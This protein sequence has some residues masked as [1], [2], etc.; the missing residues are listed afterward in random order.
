M[1]EYVRVNVSTATSPPGVEDVAGNVVGEINMQLPANIIGSADQVASARMAVM[2][3]NIPLT[4]IPQIRVELREYNGSYIES[5]FNVSFT[6]HRTLRT[7]AEIGFLVKYQN[8]FSGEYVDYPSADTG[9]TNSQY[10]SSP[11]YHF[12]TTAQEA[13]EASRKGYYDYKNIQEFLND[14]SYTVDLLLKRIMDGVVS[15]PSASNTFAYPTQPFTCSF[16]MNADSTCTIKIVPLTTDPEII[17]AIKPFAPTALSEWTNVHLLGTT[18]KSDV[19]YTDTT[20]V[21]KPQGAAI[22]VV[23]DRLR[24]SGYYGPI[25]IFLGGNEYLKEKLPSLPWSY[26]VQASFNQ[27]GTLYPAFTE[28][29]RFFILETQNAKIDFT[30]NALT[31]L[32]KCDD[33]FG[34][35][36]LPREHAEITYHFLGSDMLQ[37]NDV[38]SIILTMNGGA[39]NPQVFPINFAATTAQA[40][41]VQTIP[42]IDV[43]YPLWSTPI[44]L[45]SNLVVVR[46]AFED[47][48]PIKINP[49]LLKER[50]IKFKLYYITKDGRMHELFIPKGTPFTFQLCFELEPRKPHA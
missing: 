24:P 37:T 7:K 38:T 12:A 17:F 9:I 25:Q 1:T 42:I 45:S 10:L 46:N 6:T 33:E 49:S 31:T 36:I 16:I 48:A 41:Q 18:F 20:E 2:K 4:N 28:D 21:L 19:G 5:N 30:P 27:W 13:E 8:P 43:Y 15:V 32:Y 14:I 11:V 39:F 40:A 29:R 23:G 35:A 34:D 47:A 3:A 44:D 22:E 26:P 50:S